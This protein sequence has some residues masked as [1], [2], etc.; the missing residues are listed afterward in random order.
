MN[1]YVLGM[2]NFSLACVL[3]IV[4]ILM[5]LCTGMARHSSGIYFIVL[6]MVDL[7]YIIFR[8]VLL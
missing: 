2:T 6:L 3:N 5:V 7:I 8:T 4:S 1:A